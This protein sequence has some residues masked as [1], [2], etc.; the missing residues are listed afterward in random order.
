MPQIIVRITASTV[1][2]SV[3][4]VEMYTNKFILQLHSFIYN[5]Q[6]NVKLS[7]NVLL[8]ELMLLTNWQFD[9]CLVNVF[10][11]FV[12][13]SKN[14]VLF[15]HLIDG[16]GSFV[17]IKLL[18]R[19]L[20][21][22]G[23]I[24]P[25]VD[26]QI[27]GFLAVKN[28]QPK[29]YQ[30]VCLFCATISWQLIVATRESRDDALAALWRTGDEPVSAAAAAACVWRS[31][32]E[33][34]EAIPDDAAA[35]RCRH[36]SGHRRPC[37]RSRT[38]PCRTWL[39]FVVELRTSSKHWF[40]SL[41]TLSSSEFPSSAEFPDGEFYAFAVDLGPEIGRFKLLQYWT[42]SGFIWGNSN[43][44]PAWPKCQRC[45]DARSRIAHN[46]RRC[47]WIIIEFVA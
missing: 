29:I 1:K 26:H 11:K 4:V 46:G 36:L 10:D 42:F 24:L 39:R 23:V 41:P 33:Q 12:I 27:Y 34:V 9:L 15:L 14:G 25:R 44:C 16:F 6:L 3:V 28:L 40:G 19:V 30:C 20:G 2:Y 45:T 17:L 22:F 31:P 38:R 21:V 35:V 47:T 18:W 7:E 43:H 8:T 32:A 5:M 13:E 37:P